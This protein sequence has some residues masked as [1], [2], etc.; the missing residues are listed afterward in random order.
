MSSKINILIPAYNDWEALVLLLNKIEDA[1][2][3]LPYSF[4]YTIVNDGSNL[5]FLADTFK[6]FPLSI[7]HL[8]RNVGHQ[9]AI[10]IGLSFLADNADFEKVVVMD[11]DGED[12]PEDIEK[13]I[14]SSE[15]NPDKIIF[16]QRQKRSEGLVFRVFYMIYRF[17]FD[18][19]TGKN[20]TFGNFSL[21]PKS[22]IRNLAFVSEI[23][24][25][26]PG[27]VIR[28]RLPYTSVPL[29]R[30]TRMAGNSK[31]NFVSL[32][33]HGMSAIS[34]FLDAT[35]VRIML[36][37]ILMISA[38]SIGIF[39]VLYMK[40]IL[41]LATPGWASSL[42]SGFFIIMLQGFFISLFMVFTVLSYRSNKHFVPLLDYKPF[43]E[44]IEVVKS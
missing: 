3:H 9:K 33:L 4:H 27:G 36:F 44:S 34:V 19:L 14:N 10:A 25:N 1:T 35:A 20:I 12:K 18:V 38:S 28:S 7:I 42:A 39:V 30:G 17:I 2:K 40:F 22:K 15:Q 13:L 23:W 24:N 31:M 21:V 5:P 37:S 6:K 41:E 29:D 26:Y 16:A 32:V 43:I 8:M 11:A